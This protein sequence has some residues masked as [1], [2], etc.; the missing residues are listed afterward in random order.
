MTRNRSATETSADLTWA[1]LYNGRIRLDLKKMCPAIKKIRVT[2][3]F[4]HG[5]ARL[6][7][8]LRDAHRTTADLQAGL[9]SGA[10]VH[11]GDRK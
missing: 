9:D 11:G 6:R 8:Q 2:T 10:F 3:A 7:Q 5:A 1:E 4:S